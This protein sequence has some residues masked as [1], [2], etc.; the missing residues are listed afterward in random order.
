MK[1]NKKS[2]YFY[3]LLTTII[4]LLGC[5]LV[6]ADDDNDGFTVAEGDCD[7][8][9]D[10]VYPGAVDIP[11][12]GIDQNCDGEDAVQSSPPSCDI[13]IEPLLATV[14]GDTLIVEWDSSTLYTSEVYI[15]AFS[16]WSSADY[17]YNGVH[18][19][20]GYRE[21]ELPNGLL[22]SDPLE[23]WV[24]LE[25]AENGERTTECW[26]YAPLEVLAPSC[27]IEIQPL[28]AT[29][30]G[31][32]VEVH[33]DDTALYTSQVYVAGFS[34]WSSADYFHHEIHLN[35]S[36]IVIPL[37]TG[38][39]PSDPLEYW[40]YLES[41]ENGERTTECWD[42]APLEVLAESVTSLGEIWGTA[43]AHTADNSLNPLA[44]LGSRP[45]GLVWRL[46]LDT[47]QTEIIVEF[48]P[49]GPDN[50]WYLGGLALHPSE[51]IA[52]VTAFSYGP[53]FIPYVEA[54]WLDGYDTLI[55][56]DTNTHQVIDTWPLDVDAYSFTG[57]AQDF[58]DG[59]DGMYSPAGIQFID[60]ELY[61]IE[62]MT[63]HHPTLV[64]YDMSG[65]EP[66]L[67]DVNS[68]FAPGYWGGGVV[69]DNSGQRFAVCSE[70]PEE[71]VDQANN[72][73]AW[74]PEPY[75]W[76][77]YDMN[78]DNTCDNALFTLELD[79]VGG[80]T[81]GGN[82]TRYAV[83]STKTYWTEQAFGQEQIADL[84]VYKIHDDGS[85][86]PV[87]D[88]AAAM[89]L[90]VAPIDGLGNIDWRMP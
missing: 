48:D 64:H 57:F 24:Y 32:S 20:N 12:D 8:T 50:I 31:D 56:I 67:V 11:G 34:G 47:M 75:E 28:L 89:S 65:G 55:A 2:I 40:V 27:D 26:D 80:V 23:Y 19:N 51:P 52:Y 82:D 30:V 9:D 69:T 21:L 35:E 78:G 54:E 72:P 62:G 38:L 22:P 81:L 45:G 58:V 87:V 17:F 25:S 36:P 79:S 5:P 88:I 60:G 39:L 33:Y 59:D 4:G 53:T 86:H 15:A 83:R 77:E 13:E 46:D 43:S 37:P 6:P 14:V 3:P 84:N 41:A 42:Y 73:V 63:V 29:V 44:P 10:T 70:T 1:P 76:I 71:L 7:D 74:M 61:G 18:D 68:A 49:A 66:E 90:A 85:M 16:G